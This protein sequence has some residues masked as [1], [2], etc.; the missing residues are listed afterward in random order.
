VRNRGALID[1][2]LID[3]LLIAKA[4]F[5]GLVLS[6]CDGDIGDSSLEFE[7]VEALLKRLPH[8]LKG[9]SA[10]VVDLVKTLHAVLH[11]LSN[12]HDGV[13]I[14][15]HLA[16]SHLGGT[17]LSELRQ[18][19]LGVVA[20]GLSLSDADFVGVSGSLLRALDLSVS[21]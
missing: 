17:T 19:I 2:L 16:Q 15:S 13:D 4:L 21:R 10:N 11:D 7:S 18:D 3:W 5:L 12:G 9:L 6:E 1:K 14:L 20:H 8:V